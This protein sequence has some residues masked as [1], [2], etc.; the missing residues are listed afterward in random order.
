MP[1]AKNYDRTTALEK[2]RDAFW[3]YGYDALGVRT[4]EELTGLNR[5]AIQTDFGGK[6]GLFLEALEH[7][8]NAAIKHIIKP[9]RAGGLT[10]IKH[11]F[12]EATTLQKDDPRVFG[13]L[14]VNTVIENAAHNHFELKKRTDAHYARMLDAFTTAL[15]NARK[16]GEISEDFD[17]E[18]AASFLMG[19]AM[20][21]QVYIRM[22]GSLSS[23]RHQANM[24]LKTIDTWQNRPC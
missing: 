3:Q 21:M 12:S 16:D 7:Y 22:T 2:A 10:A 5:F 15:G 23:A 11:F 9:L 1:R 20:G 24:A 19:L 17:I 13:C 4:I 14:M 18:E 8:E 6:Q